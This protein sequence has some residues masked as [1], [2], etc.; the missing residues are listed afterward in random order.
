MI[1][2]FIPHSNTEGIDAHMMHANGTQYHFT[3]Q[4]GHAAIDDD[5]LIRFFSVEFATGYIGNYK[6]L[7][8]HSKAEEI[9]VWITKFLVGLGL[10]RAGAKLMKGGRAVDHIGR[11]AAFGNPGGQAIQSFIGRHFSS[12]QLGYFDVIT[13]KIVFP[14]GAMH[15]PDGTW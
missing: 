10:S 15:A 6:L 7:P 5:G 11:Y 3:I 13:D 1:E 8:K 2:E 4:P 12:A 9:S 14:N